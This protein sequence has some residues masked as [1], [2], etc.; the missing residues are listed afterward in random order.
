MSPVVEEIGDLKVSLLIP[1]SASCL[2]VTAIQV[3]NDEDLLCTGEQ[4]WVSGWQRYMYSFEEKHTWRG[5]EFWLVGA[6]S[7]T[8]L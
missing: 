1:E 8:G 7:P 5:A 2:S 6:N 4:S 3:K